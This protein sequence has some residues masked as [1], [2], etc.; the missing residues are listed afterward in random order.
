[1]IKIIDD[2]LPEKDFRRI[3]DT[4]EARNDFDWYL[5]P[6]ANEWSTDPRAFQFMHNQVYNST[7]QYTSAKSFIQTI[8]KPLKQKVKVHRCKTNLY[9]KQEEPIKLGFHTDYDVDTIKTLLL[10]LQDSNGYTEFDNGHKV[11]SKKNRAAIFSSN[12]KH[13]TVTQT[14]TMFRTNVNLNFEEIE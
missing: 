12:L 9:I 5:A 4:I 13:Q 1:M 8:L 2:Y 7:L 6:Q 10:Y 11:E 14:D 3:I